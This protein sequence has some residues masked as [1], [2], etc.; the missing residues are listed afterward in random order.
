M[1]TCRTQ[2]N[3]TNQITLSLVFIVDANSNLS[4]NWNKT[5]HYIKFIT[6]NFTE[7]QGDGVKEFRC[8]RN[9]AC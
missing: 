7:D 3:Q 8:I 1:L 9:G 2:P 5:Q 6:D 4:P